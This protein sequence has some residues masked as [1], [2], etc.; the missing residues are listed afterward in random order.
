MNRSTLDL[1]LASGAGFCLICALQIWAHKDI[2]YF[3]IKLAAVLAIAGLCLILIKDRDYL[4]GFF[5]AVAGFFALAAILIAFVADHEK[6]GW[7]PYFF[8]FS[9]ATA[10]FALFTRNRVGALLGIGLIVG[11]RLLLSLVLWWI[12]GYR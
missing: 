10:I 7:L 5:T 8:S 6:P 11:F 2:P 1:S 3:W 9:G 12:G 4:D